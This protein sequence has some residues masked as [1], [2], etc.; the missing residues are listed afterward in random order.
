MQLLPNRGWDQLRPHREFDYCHNDSQHLE[1]WQQPLLAALTQLVN[2]ALALVFICARFFM[3]LAG[4][5][6]RAILR[7]GKLTASDNDD[8][9]GVREFHGRKA[10]KVCSRKDIYASS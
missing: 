3:A 7:Q 6:H 1:Q 9:L 4:S 2:L 10:V 5:A 8:A